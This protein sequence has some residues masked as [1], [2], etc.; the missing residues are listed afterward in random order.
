[1]DAKKE[2]GFHL[3]R[4]TFA[5]E[6]RRLGDVTEVHDGTHQTPTYTDGGR[7]RLVAVD[8]RPIRNTEAPRDGYLAT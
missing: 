2:E 5:W 1:M 6:Q 4:N 3:D 7:N 8:D